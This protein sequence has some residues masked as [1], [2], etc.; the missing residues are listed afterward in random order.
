M[1]EQSSSR[2][3]APACPHLLDILVEGAPFL[4]L[5]RL[6]DI[7]QSVTC[8][9]DDSLLIVIRVQ[10]APETQGDTGNVP[11]GV[12]GEERAMNGR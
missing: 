11:K 8:Q 2:R 9:G 6:Q 10:F 12:L 4:L 3:F 1:L 7:P 5:H